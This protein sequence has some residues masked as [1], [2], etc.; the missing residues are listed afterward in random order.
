MTADFMVSISSSLFCTIVF[1]RVTSSCSASCVWRSFL[2][3]CSSRAIVSFS[4]GSVAMRDNKKRKKERKKE[5]KEKRLSDL[6]PAGYTACPTCSCWWRG[7]RS[8]GGRGSGGRGGR[9][10]GRRLGGSCRR[11]GR[12]QHG[13]ATLRAGRRLGWRHGRRGRHLHPGGGRLGRRGRE[14]P[15]AQR[16]VAGGRVNGLQVLGNHATRHQA[17]V[18]R[19][20]AEHGT[21]L[22][23]P[24]CP[25]KQER[26]G[27]GG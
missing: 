16:A 7:G 13:C 1:M 23:V 8:G 12:A 15:D 18:A 27:R 3:V 5:R 21:R 4:L 10:G 11:L 9:G 25:T 17:A 20:P 19:Q 22:R 24:A 2:N 26:K 14:L 6:C